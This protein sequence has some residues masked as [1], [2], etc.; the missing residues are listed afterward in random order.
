MHRPKDLKT[1]QAIIK[2]F[3]LAIDLKDDD[4]QNFKL[5]GSGWSTTDIDTSPRGKKLD[6]IAKELNVI[7]KV[8]YHKSLSLFNTD[9]N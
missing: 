8:S 2:I 6:K 4:Y 5:G 3:G 7:Q 1:L 9:C